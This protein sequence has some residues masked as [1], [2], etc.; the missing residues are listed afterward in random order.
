MDPSTARELDG[1]I[2]SLLPELVEIRRDLHAH[3]QLAYQE[4]YAASRAA[5]WL[6][7]SGVPFQAGVA[8]TGLVAW[9]LP[10]GDSQRGAKAVLLRADMDALPI[11]EET[12]VPYASTFPGVMHACGHDGHT[13]MLL[14]AASVLAR[15]REI[16]RAHV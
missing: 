1:I 11:Q 5:E 6:S 2:A 12:G 15:K 4:T 7:R 8:K 10:E 3:P 14:G 13:A 9:L 16:G